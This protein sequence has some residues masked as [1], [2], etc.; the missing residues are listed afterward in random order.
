MV[1]QRHTGGTG[2]SGASGLETLRFIQGASNPGDRRDSAVAD[3]TEIS[4][5]DPRDGPSTATG[6]YESLRLKIERVGNQF[7][8][9]IDY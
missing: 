4:H 5:C 9:I 2:K 8:V 6:T 1:V 3:P 7:Y